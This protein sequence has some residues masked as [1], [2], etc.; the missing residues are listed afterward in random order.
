MQEERLLILRKKAADLPP[1]PGVYLMKD[2]AGTILYVGKSRAL[3]NRVGS[4]FVGS[5][6]RK[7]E[8]LL[9]RVYD[10]DTVLC[11]TEIEALTLENLLIKKHAPHYNIKLKDAKS[12]PYIKITEGDYPRLIVTRDRTGDGTYFGPYTGMGDAYA[13]LEAVSRAFSLPTCRR[14]FPEDTGKERPCL[15]AQMGRCLAPCKSLPEKEEYQRTF[16]AVKRVLSGHIG[17][18]VADIEKRMLEAAEAMRF[19]EAARLRD[20]A[21]A[22][23]HLKNKQTVI[24]SSAPSCDALALYGEESGGILSLLSVREG[25]LA[26]K[27]DFRF[28]ADERTDPAAIFSFLTRL[29]EEEQLPKEILLSFSAEEADI[30]EFS[31]LLSALSGKRITV[32]TPK[33]G[34][35]KRLCDMALANAR[36]T[37]ERQRAEQV[38]SE[39]T[40]VRLASLLC[41][42]VVPERV[43]AYDISEW[44][45]EEITASMV[46][47]ANGRLRPSE[48]RLFK[49]KTTEGVDDCGAMR[50]ALTRRLLHLGDG[51]P[52][53]GT[54][55]D[56]ILLDGGVPQVH[57]VSSVLSDMGLSVPLFGMVKDD[58]HKTRS[59]TDGE[60][61]IDIASDDALYSFIYKLQEEVHRFA[62]KSV[63]NAKRKKL[64]HSALEGIPG[65][66]PKKAK[67]LLSHFGSLQRISL[68]SEEEIAA[69]SGIT[70]ADASAICHYF[71]TKRKGKQET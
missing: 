6:T 32:H 48:Y 54:A 33:R 9:S 37:Y 15:Y 46:V 67:L 40:M 47:F 12:Y 25:A 19:E 66:G 24:S 18:T 59:L 14:R 31:D 35:R 27:R 36:H 39:K 64:R 53:L 38:R 17:G 26:S 34:E 8:K 49:I 1:T 21:E 44:G 57:A 62:V 41:L 30:A 61:D 29:Y 58:R 11:H 43:E 70:R 69:L 2:E 10:F 50:E 3:R 71:E 20:S 65:I 5:H 28:S 16:K 42:E 60:N 45:K 56:L 63:Q 55:P 23:R 22:L 4:Y 52:S 7:T 68:L 51:S 13:A